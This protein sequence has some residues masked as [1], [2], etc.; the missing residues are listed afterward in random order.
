M[1][2]YIFSNILKLR[3]GIS[4]ISICDNDTAPAAP[5]APAP[6]TPSSEP[7]AEKKVTGFGAATV[8]AGAEVPEEATKKVAEEPTAAP[9]AEGTAGLATEIENL[10]KEV[11][12]D[13]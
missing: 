6:V 2:L 3:S 1:S 10:M 11:A 4:T 7:V 13:V 12:D 5:A 9:A 8:V